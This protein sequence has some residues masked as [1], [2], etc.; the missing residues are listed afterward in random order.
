MKR[1]VSSR[2]LSV[3]LAV[4]LLTLLF[5]P[6]VVRAAVS[7][8]IIQGT[9]PQLTSNANGAAGGVSAGEV[10]TITADAAKLPTY[11]PSSN[12]YRF[13]AW[14]T[15][16]KG[17]PDLA[18]LDNRHAPTTSFIASGDVTYVAEFKVIRYPG[19]PTITS[20]VGDKESIIVSFQPNADPFY[21][22]P[23]HF[24]II[25][26]FGQ[27]T[28]AASERSFR[29]PNLTNGKSY[30]IYV[31]ALYDNVEGDAAAITN[32]VA[33]PR[34]FTITFD[35]D[36]GTTLPSQQV[37]AGDKWCSLPLTLHVPGMASKDGL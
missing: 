37:A 16:P 32:V 15:D 21:S 34:M 10:V 5:T 14:D 31:T 18:A 30:D 24:N 12:F 23:D 29:I 26:S 4:V 27:H 28:V 35:S 22:T 8:T 3:M 17:G 13:I 1:L 36:G 25:G 2:Y 33:G 11:D 20:A 19:K 9:S 7:V 6:V